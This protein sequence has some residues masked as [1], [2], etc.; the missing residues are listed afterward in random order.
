MDHKVSEEVEL[1]A[2]REELRQLAAQ[3]AQQQ[4]EL[5]LALGEQQVGAAAEVQ[6]RL[7][8]LQV[9]DGVGWGALQCVLPC[10][11]CSLYRLGD[12]SGLQ[13]LQ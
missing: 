13:A 4:G 12:Q 8:A 1:A 5:R 3:V 7:L 6:R 10:T 11:Y 2:L 9:G